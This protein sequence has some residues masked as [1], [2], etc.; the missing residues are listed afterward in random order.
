MNHAKVLA[1]AFILVLLVLVALE[2]RTRASQS[3]VGPLRKKAGMI[4][5]A[6]VALGAILQYRG[7][8]RSAVTERDAA[9][10]AMKG[11]QY[12]RERNHIF[13][14]AEPSRFGGRYYRGN[15]ERS[16]HLFNG[17]F[18]STAFFDLEMVNANG[19]TL[20]VGSALPAGAGLSPGFLRLTITR[21]PKATPRLFND[22]NRRSTH[23]T[24]QLRD[25]SSKSSTSQ[26]P[27]VPDQPI[28]AQVVS[29]GEV[30]QIDYPLPPGAR[31]GTLYLASGRPAKA[32][33]PEGA[34]LG[35]PH[36]AVRY[37][38]S[39]VDGAVGPESKLTMGVIKIFGGI[40]AVPEGKIGLDEWFSFRPIPTIEGENSEDPE[41]LGIDEHDGAAK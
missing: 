26:N 12:G 9:I 19:D 20:A 40:Y 3:P 5:V 38:L 31:E 14:L 7:Q 34:Y 17:G 35:S 11:G 21:A 37:R 6:L 13:D 10:R 39:V 28:Y 36:Y 29:E 32:K 41:L 25:E 2:R 27:S 8:W 23:L 22:T 16:E 18:Y 15:D 33:D 30:W 1:P 24:T 4:L